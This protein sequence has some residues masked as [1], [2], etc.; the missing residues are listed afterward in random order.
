MIDR[1]GKKMPLTVFVKSQIENFEMK[2]L[3]LWEALSL[4]THMYVVSIAFIND[5][6]I[7]FDAS[8]DA[9]GM[10]TT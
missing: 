10:L 1:Y 2:N 6:F 7:I 4:P 5:V 3:L 9:E 8:D